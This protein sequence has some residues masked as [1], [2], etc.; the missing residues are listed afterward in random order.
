VTQEELRL[1]HQELNAAIAWLAKHGWRLEKLLVKEEI[2]L[3]FMAEVIVSYDP[4]SESLG[5]S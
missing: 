4:P 2:E 3:P 5:F 1:R